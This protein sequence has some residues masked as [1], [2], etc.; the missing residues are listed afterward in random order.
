MTCGTQIGL[1]RKVK[2]R[3]QPEKIIQQLEA[4][5]SRLAKEAI[6]ESAMNEGLDEFFEGLRMCYD[7]LYTFGVKQVPI[8]KADGQGLP[9]TAFK[10]LAEA[11]YKRDLTGHDAR[12]AIQLAMDVATKEQ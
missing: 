7:T 9:W 2:M 10:E 5:N 8:S 6:L 11:L 3:T 1:I 4:D 12:D